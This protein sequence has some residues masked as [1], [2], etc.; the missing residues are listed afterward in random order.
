LDR[1]SSDLD[2]DGIAVGMPAGQTAVMGYRRRQHFT[3]WPKMQ[4]WVSVL[5]DKSKARPPL[6]S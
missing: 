1:G 6:H 5:S 3:H 2:G 4:K